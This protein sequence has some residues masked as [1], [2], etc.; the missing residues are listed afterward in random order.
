MQSKGSKIGI[1]ISSTIDISVSAHTRLKEIKRAI[2]VS[3]AFRTGCDATHTSRTR[4]VFATMVASVLSSSFVLP[5]TR[6]CRSSTPRDSTTD[7]TCMQSS[8]L[9]RQPGQPPICRAAVTSVTSINSLNHEYT[10]TVIIGKRTHDTRCPFKLV[11]VVTSGRAVL[12][13]RPLVFTISI[14][15]RLPNMMQNN[16]VQKRTNDAY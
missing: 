3:I 1:A 13:D 7:V 16:H 9:L 4:N 2:T 15:H 6:V 8:Y 10:A 11:R 12:V 5:S 14:S